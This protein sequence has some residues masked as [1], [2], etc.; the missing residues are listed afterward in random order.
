MPCSDEDLERKA[1]EFLELSLGYGTRHYGQSLNWNEVK[2]TYV[3]DRALS[4]LGHPAVSWPLEEFFYINASDDFFDPLAR[5]LAI[6]GLLRIGTTDAIE[7]LSSL[8]TLSSDEA[9]L[10][11]ELL[12]YVL[13]RTESGDHH[14]SLQDAFESGAIDI[15][16]RF[17]K[18]P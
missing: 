10:K 11:G 18:D 17:L 1:R 3:Y 16:E 7:T 9:I 5:R 6:E 2:L 12:G 14:F 4:L 15:A 8:E 13:S